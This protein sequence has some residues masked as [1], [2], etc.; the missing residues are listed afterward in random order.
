MIFGEQI[1]F[2]PSRR[3]GD[4]LLPWVIGVMLFLTSLAVSF[5]FAIG[6]GLRDWSEDLSSTL[7]VQIVA[8]NEADRARQRS[9]AVRLLEATPGVKS[10]T[11]IAEAEVLALISPFLG[12]IPIDSGLPV[13]TLLDVTLTRPD[14]VNFAGLAERLKAAAPGAALDDHKAWLRQILAFAA[15]VQS[16]LAGIVVMV[17][18]STV[19][20][21]I[22]GCR[23]GLATHRDSI[24]IMHLMGAEDSLIARTFERRFLV[25]GIFGGAGGVIMAVL[26]LAVLIGLASDIGQGLISATVPDLTV[27][28]WLSLLPLMAG[29]L[30]MI[31]AK[32]TVMRAL[33][34]MV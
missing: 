11:V 22:F 7:S 26:I 10:V 12:D 8:E 14:A 32:I 2:L 5:G 16:V 15:V 28:I 25:H 9:A 34:A 18:A 27:L 21:V 29:L 30:T 17:A 3:E 19:A 6:T 1:E 20:I 33:K 31:T 23:A 4:G 13:P 24:D